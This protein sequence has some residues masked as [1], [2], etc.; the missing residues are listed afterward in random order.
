MTTSSAGAAAAKSKTPLIVG[1]LAV[2]A[3][4]G[5]GGAYALGAFDGIPGIG[6]D[7][8]PAD[9]LPGNSIMY[10]SADFDP[11]AA[12][13][14]SAFRLLEKL[15]DAKSALDSGDPKKAVFDMIAKDNEHMSGI[16]YEQDV[17]PWL[18]DRAGMAM[19][20]P[21]S[22]SSDPIPVVAVQVTDQEKANAGLDKLEAVS[23]ETRADSE[24]SGSP[25]G[26]PTG[27]AES[28]DSN[29]SEDVK[30]ARIFVDD[31]V[32]L[33][34]EKDQAA[35]QQQIDAGRL[36]A[37]EQFTGDMEGVGDPGVASFWVNQ[38]ELMKLTN[39]DSSTP[40]AMEQLAQTAGRTAATL[41]FAADHAEIASISRDVQQPTTGTLTNITD[42]PAD[43]VGVYSFA[44][45]KTMVNEMWPTVQ[46]ALDASGNDGQKMLDEV[47][48]FGI[49]LPDD[50]GT[51]LGDQFDVIVGQQDYKALAEGQGEELP[52]AAIRV[53][54]DTAQ[55]EQ[56]LDKVVSNVGNE[57]GFP[58]VIP[59]ETFG[60]RL[61]IG[62]NN[63]YMKTLGQ[64][65]EQGL[66]SG[67]SFQLTVP[68]P[69]KQSSLMYV[70]L[71][72][73]EEQY[74]D[75]VP[76]DK[77][78]FVRA[79]Q[80]FGASQTPVENGQSTGLIRLSVN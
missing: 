38:G 67:A 1:G 26:A 34:D 57:M 22:G 24:K 27:A 5:A 9:V 28:A 44:G 76:E 15:P 37:Q 73:I 60:D 50:L 30:T 7:A 75:Q 69:D 70:N 49:N 46:S 52:K 53:K 18:G 74:I 45:G 35:V 17:K 65:A 41:R 4:A 62:V 10:A 40:A 6:N 78:E 79:L 64:P 29:K 63:T 54:T 72:S 56:I 58:L 47:K 2:L 66:G 59:R 13:K 14:I 43:T 36:S 39:A 61:A 33:M 31:Y 71:D 19:L 20:P 32:L 80:A 11:S 51:L 42:L 21:A 8:Q 68:E 77:R 3:V 55:A 48:K 25:V 23:K 12:Q 16:D